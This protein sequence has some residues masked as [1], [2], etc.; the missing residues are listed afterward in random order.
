M[1]RSKAVSKP[2]IIVFASPKGG[3]GK[4][5]LCL[6][7]AGAL[8]KQGAKVRI[9][10]IDQNQTLY[11][12]YTRHQPDIK[13]LSVAAI[14]PDVFAEAL[15]QEYTAGHDIILIDVAGTADRVML[16]AASAADLIITPARLSEPDIQQATR[17][18]AEVEMMTRQFKQRIPHQILVNDMDT[19]D[20]HYQRHTL[21]E[22]TRLNLP[23]FETLIYKRAAYRESFMTGKPPHFADKSRA[24]VKKTVEEI[25]A[26]ADEVMAIVNPMPM[27]AAANDR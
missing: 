25:D 27:K 6:A 18:L 9:L 1:N 11:S 22:L 20:P 19:L 12:W 15:Q 21:A 13:G 16:L 8:A 17:L 4:S 3:V 5:P 2:T 14:M 10:D 7:L 24:A 26:L 23:R